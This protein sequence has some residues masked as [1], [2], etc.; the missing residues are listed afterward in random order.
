MK[1]NSLVIMAGGA[2]TRMKRSL[3]NS[4]LNQ[5]VLD[6]AKKHHKSLIPLGKK[7]RPLLYFLLQNAVKAGIKTVYLITSIENQAFKD[8]IATLKDDNLFDD[9]EVNF[10]IQHLV[11]GREKPLGT[12]D[13]LQQC[14]EQYG[15]LKKERFTVC[16]GD[17][18]Y[19]VS[20][21]KALSETRVT[22]N[23]LIAYDGAALGH[24]QEKITKFALLD[25]NKDHLLTNIIEKP[26]GKEL[27]EYGRKHDKFWVSMNIFNFQGD[28]IYP[29]LCDC[30]IHPVRG[31]KELPGAVKTAVTELPGSVLC[32]PRSEKIPDLTAAQD[33]ASFFD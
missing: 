11:E 24:S 12:A 28:F 18:L 23:A 6:V 8:F 13:A 2:S 17:N 31:E 27:R 1:N 19:D 22:S 10:A 4:N 16:N 30:P 26:E 25:F 20:A 7:G 29:F 32:I 9:L 14:L 15:I 33:I 3:E 5:N 21:L